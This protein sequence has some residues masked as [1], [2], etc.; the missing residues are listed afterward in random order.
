VSRARTLRPRRHGGPFGRRTATATLA[1]LLVLGAAAPAGAQT[2]HEVEALDDLFLPAEVGAAP[3]DTVRWS[4]EQTANPV[5]HDVWVRTPGGTNTQVTNGVVPPGSSLTADYPVPATEGVY[6]F[7]CSLHGFV[8]SGMSGEIRVGNVDPGP[9]GPQPFPNPSAPPTSFEVGDNE[10][11]KVG[12]LRIT[13]IR[14]GVR[15]RFSLSEPG[16]VDVVIA[17]E[18]ER[19]RK[20]LKKVAAG[21]YTGTIRDA[22]L[23]AGRYLVKMRAADLVGNRAKPERARV[24]IK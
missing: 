2:T 14:N 19:V 4:F 6:E 10:R 5:G 18:G 15:M 12:G 17:G 16:R 22:S 8:N 1:C 3:G 23:D 24:R 11:P 20:R 13:G 21:A 9:V 7:F